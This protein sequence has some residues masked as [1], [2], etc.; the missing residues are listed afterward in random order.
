MEAKLEP[1]RAARSWWEGLTLISGYLDAP[2]LNRVAFVNGW[3]RTGDMGS[4]DGDGFLT[5][6]GREQEFINR[7]GEKISP[8]EIDHA[9][10]RHPEVAEAAAFAV[11]HPRLGEDVAAAVVLREGARVTPMG[12]RQFLASQLAL[13]KVPRR[14]VLVNHL[15]KG[16]TGK[17]LRR[18]LVSIS[19]RSRNPCRGG[20]PNPC[21]PAEAMGPRLESTDLSIDDNFL[22][23]GGDSLLATELMSELER[24]IGKPIRKFPVRSI[25]HENAKRQTYSS[26]SCN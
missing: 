4:L 21:R 5:L 1:V 8:L 3:F 12:F 19:N 7:G 16:V 11:P 18:W 10:L 22:D 20:A 23:K 9:L 14:I 15:P 2:D 17:I 13:S 25:D 6:L 24:L 26:A